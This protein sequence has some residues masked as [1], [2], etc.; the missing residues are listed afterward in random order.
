MMEYD[1][2]VLE[3][4]KEYA[5]LSDIDINNIKYY[6]LYNPEIAGDFAFRKE[7]DD[8]LVG[9]DD[10]KE[11]ELVVRNLYEK[12][13]DNEALVKFLTENKLEMKPNKG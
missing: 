9:L 4:G 7:E 11:F 1:T 2:I 13:K 6:V 12:N 8:E 10:E 3:T 5:V